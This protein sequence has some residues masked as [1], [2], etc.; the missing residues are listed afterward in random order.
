MSARLLITGTRGF[1]GRNLKEHFLGTGRHEV[2]APLREELDLLDHASVSSYVAK[3]KPDL[4]IHCATVGG[5]RKTAY[6]S[7]AAGVASSNIRMFMNLARSLPAGARM[8]SMGTGAEY[9]HRA[10]APKMAEEYFD[11]S[12]PADPY[13]FSK[14]VVSKFIER[15]ENVAC[16]R[17]FGLFGR[18]EDYT[19]KFISNAIVKSLLGLPITINQNVVFDYL[20]IADFMRIVE[21]FVDRAPAHRHYN[22]T[23]TESIDLLSLANL[24]NSAGG[25]RSEIRVLN[26]G[27]NREYTGSNARLVAELPG[28]RFTPYAEAVKELYEYYRTNLERLDT[29]A[30]KADP[31][32]KNCRTNK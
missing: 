14:Y 21:A 8:I 26:P 30:V 25:G 10:Y 1:V 28:F 20:Y 6:D 29:A 16:L 2:L 19:F 5:T 22:A 27:L 12:V 9:D 24:V 13:G 31:Y 32:I 17:I 23:P 3:R 11:S 15:A 7:G 4:V 18:Y